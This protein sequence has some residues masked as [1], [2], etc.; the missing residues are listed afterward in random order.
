MV[1]SSPYP[2]FG[3]GLPH[4]TSP[5]AYPT[6]SGLSKKHVWETR[7][8]HLMNRPAEHSLST[9]K[10]TLTAFDDMRRLDT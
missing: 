1:P 2:T 6:S 10:S 3:K 4:S 7:S 5:G 8:I 9:L